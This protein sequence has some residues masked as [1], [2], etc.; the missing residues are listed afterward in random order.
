[1]IEW[2]NFIFLL[3]SLFLFSYFYTL[4]V[5]PVKREK[6]KG[7]GAWKE[8]LN[9]FEN[10]RLNTVPEPKIIKWIGL[11]AHKMIKKFFP[12]LSDRKMESCLEDYHNFLIEDTHKFTKSIDG[13]MDALKK[14]KK[15]WKLALVSGTFK[16]EIQ[17]L[18]RVEE[19][20]LVFHLVH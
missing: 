19:K 3:I 15:D 8:C 4:S 10:N 16:A 18:L 1:M 5:Q 2:I 14:L 9:D 17:I 13:A 12:K 6:K 20:Q 7:E 11:D